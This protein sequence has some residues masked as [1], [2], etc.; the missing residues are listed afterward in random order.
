MYNISMRSFSLMLKDVPSEFIKSFTQLFET[1]SFMEIEYCALIA[2]PVIFAVFFVLKDDKNRWIKF[3]F[4]FFLFF[5][6]R[7]VFLIALRSDIGAFRLVYFGKIGIIAF[8]LSVLM[9]LKQKYV[10]NFLFIW[11]VLSISLFVLTNF[12]I[13]KVQYLGFDAGRRY[14]KNLLDKVVTNENF[15][16]EKKYISFT[17]GYPNFRNKFYNGRGLSSE[18]N[19]HAMVFY[20]DT[21]NQLFWEENFTPVAVGAGILDNFSIL[22]VNRDGG[23]FWNDQEYWLDNPENMKAIRM[24]LYTQAKVGD[25]YIDDKYILAVLDEVDFYKNRELVATS[26]DK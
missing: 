15:K 2:A 3:L 10:K 24:W 22:R 8:S 13:H 21:I 20:F 6:S 4:L 25:I 17:F 14:Q 16:Y 19:E 7:F 9:R 11:G 12:D 26:L 23:E 18:M 5:V 1:Y